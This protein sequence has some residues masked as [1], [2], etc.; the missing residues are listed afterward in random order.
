VGG[1][2]AAAGVGIGVLYNGSPVTF[3]QVFS[4]PQTAAGGLVNIPFAARYRYLG[5]DITA[6]S[7][8][9]S[10]TFTMTAL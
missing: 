5:G 6:G 4:L 2:G 1:S 8:N 10:M 3:K 9:A 7:V